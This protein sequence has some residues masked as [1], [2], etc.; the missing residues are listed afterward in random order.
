MYYVIIIFLVI[1]DQVTK[2]MVRQDFDLHQSVPVIDGIFHLTYVQNRG[3][4][5]SMFQ[6]TP[7]LTMV[8][9]GLVVAGL[10][11]YMFIYGKNKPGLFKG[12]VALILSGGIGNLIDRVTLGFVT[13][14]FD[15]RIWP[16]FNVADIAVCVG[17]FLMILYIFKGD[18]YDI[19][20]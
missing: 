11:G 10:L 2:W 4:A 5:F 12:A 7:A 18:K 3:A 13:D 19:N 20:G 17:C 16:V 6:D 9:P 15:F 14:F 8:F 1:L